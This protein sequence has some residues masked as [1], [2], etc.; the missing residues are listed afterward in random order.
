MV[1]C[2]VTA[3]PMHSSARHCPRRRLETHPAV[4]LVTPMSSIP[5]LRPGSNILRP[6]EPAAQRRQADMGPK[7][8]PQAHPQYQP[9]GARR[10]PPVPP[11]PPCAPGNCM[12]HGNT[13]T[14]CIC[15]S[16][17]HCWAGKWG[18]R[19]PTVLYAVSLGRNGPP[20]HHPTWGEA[21]R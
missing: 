1:F 18:P 2:A 14:D 9:P 10:C 13:A 8:G 7:G 3:N 21:C 20:A 6:V 19:P 5:P 17:P 15:H 16:S 4:P 12:P 11:G